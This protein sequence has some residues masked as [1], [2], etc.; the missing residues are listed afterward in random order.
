[1]EGNW[2]DIQEWHSE[3]AWAAFGVGSAD[4]GLKQFVMFLASSSKPFLI[5]HNIQNFLCSD[6]DTQF[7]K[8]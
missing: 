8:I 6:Y 4:E 2:T 3:A 1:M 5:G 7:T